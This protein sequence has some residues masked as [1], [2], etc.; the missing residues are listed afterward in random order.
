MNEHLELEEAVIDER[1]EGKDFVGFSIGSV[2]KF[3][4]RK[5]CNGEENVFLETVCDVGSV[6]K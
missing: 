5:E 6:I 1:C 3:L 2:L 4:G